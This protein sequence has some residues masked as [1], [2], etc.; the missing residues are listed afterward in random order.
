MGDAGEIRIAGL[1]EI[2]E[3]ERCVE[4]QVAVWGYSE[5]DLI[6]KRVFLVAQR[7]GGQVIGA[8]DDEAGGLL[9]GFCLS[10]P[11]Y[12]E[13]RAYLHSH[14][15]AVLPDY[16]NAGLGRRLKLAQREDALARGIELMEWT[17]D[18]LEIKN[19]HLNIARL[20]A[21]SRR[22]LPDFYGASSSPLQGGL[23]TD[24]LVAEWWLGSERVRRAL[25]QEAGRGEGGSNQWIEQ[26]A[27]P[28]EVY[29]WKRDPAGRALAEALQSRNRA[30]LESAFARGL[31]VTG[32][33]RSAE[34]DGCFLL[35]RLAGLEGVD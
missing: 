12:R 3:F 18:P 24:R 19:A 5:S 29:A 22:Y 26:V 17:F 25:G 32:Y 14:M 21:I 11:G 1:T 33:T 7:I 30:A 23:P 34:G 31:A 15:L 10:L 16:R 20:G 9:V 35:G 27:V 4:L 8:F 6:P 28:K 2:A 13:G